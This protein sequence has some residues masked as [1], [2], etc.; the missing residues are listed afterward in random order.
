MKLTVKLEESQ[1]EL[2]CLKLTIGFI[3]T[4]YVKYDH[5]H[6][7]TS[8]GVFCSLIID[9]FQVPWI[10]LYYKTVYD[11]NSSVY[12]NYFVVSKTQ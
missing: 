10:V 3:P 8:I 5:Y 7:T 6:M 12:K 4:R 11:E 9:I 2:Q 1:R